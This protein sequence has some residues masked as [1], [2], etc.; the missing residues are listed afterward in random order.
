MEKIKQRIERFSEEFLDD[1]VSVRRQIHSNPELSFK[2]YQTSELIADFLTTYRIEFKKGIAKTGIVGLI[3]GKNPGKKTVALRADMDALPI[4]ELNDAAYKSKNPGKMHACGHDVHIA[5]LIGTAR[6]LQEIKNEFEGTVKLI[7][8]PSEEKYP[9]GAK[10]MIEEGVLENPKPDVIFG[11]HVFPELEAGQIGMKSGKYMAST[12]E[13]FLTVKGKGGHGAIPHKNI[14]P[15]LITSHIIVAL[16]QIVSRNSNPAMPTV[17]SFGRVIADGQTNVIP[18]KV[19]IAGIMRTFDEIW[20]VEMKEKIEKMAQYIAVSMG[21]TC[22][23]FFDPG[24]PVLVN[25]KSITDKTEKYAIEYLG[26]ENVKKL[27]L[28]TT[29]EDFAYYAQKVPACFYRLGVRNIDKGIVSNLHTATFDV[30]EDSLKTGMGLM[31]WVTVKELM[32]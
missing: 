11:Q 28:R 19:S 5:S 15:V 17:L 2:E 20:R 31:A 29:A 22:D 25:E 9:G 1:I 13:I 14:D 32:S 16:Q 24:Y 4:K 30:D 8:Q 21:G 12:D 10:V 27:E 3:K 23:V 26:E 6:I 18:D 7:F